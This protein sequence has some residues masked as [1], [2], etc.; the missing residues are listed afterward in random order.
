MAWIG[1]GFGMILENA[2]V[3]DRPRRRQDPRKPVLGAAADAKADARGPDAR[4]NLSF[5][6]TGWMAALARRLS[7][8]AGREARRKR[9]P[10]YACYGQAGGFRGHPPRLPPHSDRVFVKQRICAP[11]PKVFERFY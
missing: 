8:A 7:T 9:Q 2:D 10:G 4:A 3:M 1:S 11:S 6:A 5:G